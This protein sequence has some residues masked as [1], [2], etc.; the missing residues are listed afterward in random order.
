MKEPLG[1]AHIIG[2]PITSDEMP[3]SLV[4]KTREHAPFP[5]STVL[6]AILLLDR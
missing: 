2:Q 3:T 4:Y 5:L 1:V 6:S